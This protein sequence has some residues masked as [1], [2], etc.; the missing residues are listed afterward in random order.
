MRPVS[1]TFPNMPAS[2]FVEGEI[3]KRAA[4]LDEQCVG[5][6]SC[7]VVADIPHRHHRK[8][9]ALRVHVAVKVRGR[10]VTVT[11]EGETAALRRVIREAFDLAKQQLLD[12]RAVR[13]EVTR[14]PARSLPRRP[15]GRKVL[16]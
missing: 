14:R 9:N 1:I 8:G 15:T 5:I 3:R 6:L 16:D 11:R 12:F 4:K 7:A 13:R 2:P 10:E